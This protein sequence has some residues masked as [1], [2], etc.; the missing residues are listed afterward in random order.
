MA[1][2]EEKRGA[3]DTFGL[4]QP[5]RGTLCSTPSCRL[6]FSVVTFVSFVSISPDAMP[7]TRIP[8]SPQ[9]SPTVRVRPSAPAL[10]ALKA[11]LPFVAAIE[12]T[13]ISEP[14]LR[15]SKS[16]NFRHPLVQGHG[17]RFRQCRG[18]PVNFIKQA[19][20]FELI[21]AGN[22]NHIPSLSN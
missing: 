14:S 4:A 15:L 5:F 19:N 13:I 3:R 6:A 18:R 2:G 9:A 7:L 11:G 22:F 12:P 8:S 16:W 17:D 1:G 10:E 21:V 20:E